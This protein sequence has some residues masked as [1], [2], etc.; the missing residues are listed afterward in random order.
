MNIFEVTAVGAAVAV[1]TVFVIWWISRVLAEF[2]ESLDNPPGTDEGEDWW[3]DANF[4]DY[5]EWRVR[6]KNSLDDTD[7]T[8]DRQ[9]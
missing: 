8:E 4:T 7:D 3:K 1:A 9:T 6:T 5:T 2:L